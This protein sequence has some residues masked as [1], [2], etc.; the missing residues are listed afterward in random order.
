MNIVAH[1]DIKNNQ[2]TVAAKV[3]TAVQNVIAV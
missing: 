3:E 1:L 2:A